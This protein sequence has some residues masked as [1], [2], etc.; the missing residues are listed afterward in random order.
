MPHGIEPEVY[1]VLPE[2]KVAQFRQALFGDAPHVTLMV[3]ANKGFDRK[4]FQVAA[5]RLGG[6]CK[7]EP[8]ALLYI[9]T[10]PTA[11]AQGVDLR[12]LTDALGIAEACALSRPLLVLPGLSSRIHGAALQRRRRA[13]GGEHE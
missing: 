11:Q 2:D 12:A 1:K 4:A 7:E 8:G 5:R 6:L 13:A 10:D 9:H 3:A